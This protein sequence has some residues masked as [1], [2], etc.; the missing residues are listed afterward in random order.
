MFRTDVLCTS[1]V[2]CGKMA[3]EDAYIMCQQELY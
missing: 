1:S 2:S 3:E